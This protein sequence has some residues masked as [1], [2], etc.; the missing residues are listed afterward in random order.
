MQKLIIGIGGASGSIYAKQ[1]MELVRQHKSRELHVAV[2][3]TKNGIANWDLEIGSFDQSAF[4]FDF[5]ANDDFSAPFASGSS[6]YNTMIICP[7]SMGLIGRISSG[8]STDLIT[9]AADVILKERRKLILVPRETPLSLIH[10]NNMKSL[11]EAG[12]IICPAIPSF[13]HNP[14]T[15][16]ELVNTVVTRVADLAGME[17][18]T[19]RWGDDRNRV[20]NLLD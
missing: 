1:L 18:S 3:M 5:F 10:L 14:Q 8:H 15:V 4:P 13:Y 11:T 6:Q 2:V 17:I 12:A 20:N 19:K 7:C 9:R 16:E